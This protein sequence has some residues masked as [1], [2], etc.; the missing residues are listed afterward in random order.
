M[1]VKDAIKLLEANDPEQDII[2]AWWD[3]ASFTLP[4]SD[5]WPILAD[6]ATEDMDWSGAQEDIQAL[7]DYRSK[8]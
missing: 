4:S 2:I 1:K 7:I 6:A 8:Y 5:E 3:E